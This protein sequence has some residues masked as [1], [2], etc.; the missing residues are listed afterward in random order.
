MNLMTLKRFKNELIILL[1]SLFVLLSFGYKL[2]AKEHVAKE[3]IEIENSM[4]QIGKVS[5]LKQLWG[6]KGITKE[7]EKFKTVVAKSKIKSFEKRSKKMVAKYENLNVKELNSVMNR[8]LNTPFQ[9]SK[10]M[11][12]EQAKEQYRMEFTCKW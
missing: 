4:T 7:A 3:I 10:L 6:D 5:G 11:V 1:A 9:I 2:S 12:R 8:L